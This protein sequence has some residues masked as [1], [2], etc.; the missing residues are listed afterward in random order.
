[1]DH[2]SSPR[3]WGTP[4][5]ITQDSAV[6][7]FIPTHVG[8]APHATPARSRPPVHPH[9]RGERYWERL[10]DQPSRGS[11]PRTWGTPKGYRARRC[12]RRFIP[13][14]VGNAPGA[15]ESTAFFPVHPHARG[16]RGVSLSGDREV[17]GSSPR[18]WG[19]PLVTDWADARL[20]FIPTHV[21]NACLLAPSDSASAVHPHARGERSP[22]YSVR[23][24][25][26]GSSPRTWGTQAQELGDVLF[27]RFIPTHVGNAVA[28]DLE[29]IKTAVHPHA[30]GERRQG[31]AD[32]RGGAGSSPRT[33]GTLDDRFAAPAVFRF[34]PTHVGN[35]PG[36]W[37]LTTLTAGSSPRTW[38][39]LRAHARHALRHRFI[40]THVG[41]AW[42]LCGRTAYEGGSSPRTWGT[43]SHRAIVQS[44]QR[45]IPTH[46]G[47]AISHQLLDCLFSVHPHARGERPS[48][49]DRT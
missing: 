28:V 2:G 34:I 47:N 41:N 39:T 26:A 7:R 6:I 31:A 45:F 49:A 48:G 46:V 33:W 8:N 14:H 36:A 32:G 12:A 38:G 21:G 5:T 35:A 23:C 27:R 18:T 4:F 3:T 17:A 44:R 19:T 13:T 40:P 15:E 22:L 1:M 20:R 11:S 29:K 30:R 16:E 43:R 9:A 37:A 24:S 25:D 42:K 10:I